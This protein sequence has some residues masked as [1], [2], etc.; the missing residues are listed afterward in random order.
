MNRKEI[1]VEKLVADNYKDTKILM[2]GKD[3]VQTNYSLKPVENKLFQLVLYNNQK[4]KHNGICE[5]EISISELAN[6]IGNKN[7]R[8]LKEIENKLKTIMKKSLTFYNSQIKGEYQLISG[9]EIMKA[10]GSINIIMLERVVEIM[11][12]YHKNKQISP[13][14]PI[15]L[16]LFFELR[17]FYS[18]KLYD[19][20]RLW[21]RH[22]KE[23]KHIF[24]L[25]EIRFVTG[26]E[27][28]YPRW[29]NFS[30]KVLDVACEE[31]NAKAKMKVS[32]EAK[33]EKGT[34]TK[35]EFTILDYEPHVYFDNN[36]L[37]K[38][39]NN[40]KL[41]DLSNLQEDF[42][43]YID[44]E[45]KQIE[46]TLFNNQSEE[47]NFIIEQKIES[48][49][50]EINEK[51]EEL[52]S[53]EKT[54][55][56]RNIK[57]AEGALKKF[58]EDFKHIDF[59]NSIYYKM[60]ID[61]YTRTIDKTMNNEINTTKNYNYFKKVLENEIK[62]FEEKESLFNSEY[63]DKNNEYKDENIIVEEVCINKE[64]NE[65]ILRNIKDELKKV[66]TS[67]GVSEVSINCWIESGIKEI[68][69]K[70]KTIYFIISNIFSKDMILRNYSDY[71]QEIA[72]GFFDNA[73]K[74]EYVVND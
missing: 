68:E 26:T 24:L 67:N 43:M 74:V 20:L 37:I 46:N 66:L 5:C 18:Q 45:V 48:L 63:E 14:A 58:K 71:I 41:L 7:E 52:N 33:K 70:N 9:Y 69:I 65:N 73:E 1:N 27:N 31:I 34:V 19:E 38:K 30:Q 2:K 28:K 53:S 42:K 55:I 36:K 62:L 25:S 15:N 29:S 64:Y 23:I 22:N 50:K 44:K 13:Y 51:I 47:D 59:D 49:M 3:I 6:V 56:E 72:L 10:K 32:Y 16:S 35:V 57:I 60:L 61:A 11:Q 4:Q 12:Q 17:S 40:I 21:S 8:T 39:I 54:I